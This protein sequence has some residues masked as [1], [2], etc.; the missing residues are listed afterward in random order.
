M[1]RH[2]RV[3]TS[4]SRTISG[5]RCRSFGAFPIPPPWVLSPPRQ[6]SSRSG[7]SNILAAGNFRSDV[8]VH[9]GAALSSTHRDPKARSPERLASHK[10]GISGCDFDKSR[11]LAAI[12]WRLGTERLRRSC[13]AHFDIL[14]WRRGCHQMA[15]KE[16][17]Y[18]VRRKKNQTNKKHHF[19]GFFW[20]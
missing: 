14:P 1:S 8:R 18:V 3:S 20:G 9:S 4:F 16:D 12:L 5:P 7:T 19:C 6:G 15:P 13:S 10:N 17:F 11:V 2:V